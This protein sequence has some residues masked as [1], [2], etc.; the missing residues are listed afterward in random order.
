MKTRIDDPMRTGIEISTRR[1]VY[2][3]MSTSTAGFVQITD[4]GRRGVRGPLG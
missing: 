3:S 4:P 2:A 1:M